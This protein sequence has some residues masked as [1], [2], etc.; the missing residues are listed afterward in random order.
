MLAGEDVLG[1]DSVAAAAK[2]V[3][4]A[5]PEVLVAPVLV[6]DVVHCTFGVHNPVRVSK[7]A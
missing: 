3:T 2:G 5:V 7:R 6:P 4:L 1:V